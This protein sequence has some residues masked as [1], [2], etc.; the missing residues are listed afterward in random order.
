MAAGKPPA[1]GRWLDRALATVGLQRAI[2][3]PTSTGGGRR[4]TF[5]AA[6]INRLT[7][8]LY[9]DILSG[10]DELQGDLRRLRGL[11]RRLSRDT[12]Y[13]AR[14]PRL[15]SE[16]TLGL[17]GIRLQARIE[18]RAGGRNVGLNRT[19]EDEWRLWGMPGTCT[20]DGQLSWADVQ[21]NVVENLA[22]DG[23]ALVRHVRGAENPWGYTLQLLDIDLLDEQFTGTWSN[24]NQVVM[25]VEIDRWQ[26]PV[27]YHLWTEHPSTIGRARFRERIPA[28]ELEL[29]F[30][31]RRSGQ[32]RG[33]PWSAPILLDASTLGAYLEAAVHAARIGASRMAAIERDPGSEIDE[34]GGD[35]P[36]S[37]IPDEVAPGQ[38]LNLDAGQHLKSIDWQYP[39]GEI[40][41]FTRIIVRS[42]ATGW[43]TSYA[44][45]S[46]DL[47][48]ANYSSMRYGL[49]IERDVWRRV[50]RLLI[51]RLCWPVF[52]AWRE[53]AV[54]TNRIPARTS[55]TDYDR[56]MWQPRGWPWT[57]PVKEVQA[58]VLA[59]NNLLTT[60]TR[61]LGEQG[62]D[63]AELA[64]EYAEE[65]AM[66]AK[67]GL[68][69]AEDGQDTP[70]DDDDEDGES[71]ARP[72]LPQKPTRTIWRMA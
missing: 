43:N 32:Q 38:M 36:A 39:T 29:I 24:G 49:L 62:V 59:L 22:V 64:E 17:D 10:N 66:L 13:G 57:D 12:A 20:V 16:Q 30:V 70:I 50:Q 71:A 40:D 1:G 45:L 27:A 63:F 69:R 18:K 51:H 61:I 47:T 25:G 2:P 19:L 21:T 72:P 33:V 28:S 48:G 6:Q 8:D 58:N 68:R 52:R 42:L 11:S 55:M 7:A 31:A 41:P 44:S 3:R 23:E 34:D 37:A 46:G 9:A 67:L 4:R 53:M 56:V 14:Y 5:H 26:K 60:R 15:V 35:Q 65:E 54:I